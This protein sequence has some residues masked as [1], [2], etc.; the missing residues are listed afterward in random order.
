[1]YSLYRH[2]LIVHRPEWAHA[3]SCT[4]TTSESSNQA[5]NVLNV[6]AVIPFLFYFFTVMTQKHNSVSVFCRCGSLL[7]ASLGC[8]PVVSGGK[9]KKNVKKTTEAVCK[10]QFPRAF[11]AWRQLGG[12]EST[13]RHPR[14]SE[15]MTDVLIL[16]W[17]LCRWPVMQVLKIQLSKHSSISFNST[18]ATSVWICVRNHSAD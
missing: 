3:P 5:V 7:C 16:L 12:G 2:S 8:K 11:T 9:K 15:F 1:M 17:D 6:D 4:H 14:D 18:R 13:T 10:L